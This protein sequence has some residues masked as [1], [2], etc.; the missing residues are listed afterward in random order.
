MHYSVINYIQH[1]IDCISMT[2][3][4]RF[5]SFESLKYIHTYMCVNI[6]KHAIKSVYTHIYIYMY[7]HTYIHQWTIVNNATVNIRMHIYLF[8]L[9]F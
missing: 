9:V 8:D 3:N 2:Y 6:C 4:W 1:A 7:I 5:Y